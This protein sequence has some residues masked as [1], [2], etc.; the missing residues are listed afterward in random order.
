M[1]EWFFKPLQEGGTI[2]EPIHGEFFS[3]DAISEPGTALIR[4]GIQNSLDQPS[5]D[6]PV[7]VRIYLSGDEEAVPNSEVREYFDNV[8]DHYESKENGLHPDELPKKSAQCDFIVFEDFATT[9][10]EGDPAQA[11]KAKDGSKNHFYH[12]FRA[13][14]QT[15]KQDVELGSWGVGKFVFYRSSR[16]ST[17]FG[18]TNRKSDKEKML[19]GKTI[20]KSHWH[21]NEYCQEGYYGIPPNGEDKLVMPSKNQATIDK[22]SKTFNLQRGKDESGL[23]IVVPWPDVEIDEKTIVTAVLK[24]YFYPIL[25]G[26]LEVIIETPT[27]KVCLDTDSLIKE[28]DKLDPDIITEL[29]PLVKLTKWAQ[30][31]DEEERFIINRPDRDY[32]WKWSK[33]LINEGQLEQLKNAYFNGEKIA[34]RVPVSV[35]KKHDEPKDT[36]FDIY[37]TRDNRDQLGRP[38]FIRDGIIISKVD[39]P[40]TRG[41]R[42]LVIAHDKPITKFLRKAENPSHTEWQHVQLKDDYKIGYATD[43]DFVKRSIHEL[44]RII[45]ETEKEEDPTLLVDFFSLPKGVIEE[46]PVDTTEPEDGKENGTESTESDPDPP[47]NSKSFRIRKIDGGFSILPTKNQPPEKLKIQIAYDRRRGNPLK[48]YNKADFELNEEPIHYEPK[49]QNIEIDEISSNEIVLQIQDSDFQFHVKGFDKRR[50]LYI[51]ANQID[52][53]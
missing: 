28:I 27:Y 3:T 43:L 16:V 40:R 51:R 2:R 22:F 14:G 45:S 34:I 50:Q 26:E 30:N 36:F 19:M 35:K 33:D 42:S 47:S 41:V 8:W 53:S 13:E 37:L 48:K 44:V 10:L 32:A 9:G 39:A 5:E 24:D 21:N 1:A 6:E 17:I 25:I 23:S 18:L 52:N 46:E 31:I 29:K 49:P 20:L 11:F 7:L 12:F 4:E 38:V 15:D